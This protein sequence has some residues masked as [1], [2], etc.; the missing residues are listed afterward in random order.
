MKTSMIRSI[1]LVLAALS[2]FELGCYATL[3]VDTHVY[4]GSVAPTNASLLQHAQEVLNQDLFQSAKRDELGEELEAS[5]R[6]LYIEGVTSVIADGKK[7]HAQDAGQSLDDAAIEQIETDARTTATTV[8][9]TAEPTVEAAW[10]KYAALAQEVESH[11]IELRK[12]SRK[13]GVVD[14][15]AITAAAELD[16]SLAVL[17]DEQ[18]A[19]EKQLVLHLAQGQY[20]AVRRRVLSLVELKAAPP[21]VAGIAAPE[22]LTG[23]HVGYP[24]FDQ[25]ILQVLAD[26]D[27]AAWTSFSESV[28]K[29]TGGNAQFVAKSEGQLIF[30]QKSLDFDPTPVVGAGTAVAKVAAEIA[31]SVAS[32]AAGIPLPTL[33]GKE[34]SET[35]DYASQANQADLDAKQA[36]LRDRDRARRTFLLELARLH[37]AAAAATDSNER[38]AIARELKTAITTF[39]VS[40]RLGDGEDSISPN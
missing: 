4:T 28:F 25:G 10:T 2:L 1:R 33:G 29:T 22:G 15:E 11:A 19:L 7:Q 34:S 31:A 37:D 9:N 23:R 3:R 26:D 5:V 27:E 12:R 30:R 39:E 16:E 24:L 40:S 8:W 20:P 17:R 18:A 21:S 32:S 36:L 38:K 6:E 14:D 35:P 13:P